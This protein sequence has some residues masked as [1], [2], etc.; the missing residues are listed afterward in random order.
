MCH[1]VVPVIES[2]QV[3]EARRV[4][5][6]VAAETLLT[7]ADRGKV[8]IVATEMANN[9]HRHARDGQILIRVV[10][11]ADRIG[12]EL[13]SIDRGP[14]MPNIARCMEDGF[15]SGGTAG[16][17]LGAI[18][19]L[20]AEFDIYSAQPSG[21]VILCRGFSPSRCCETAEL[22]ILQCGVVIARRGAGRDGLRR[23]LGRCAARRRRHGHDRRRSGPRRFGGPGVGRG[24]SSISTQS[25]FRDSPAIFLERAH[26]PLRSTRGAAVAAAYID[27]AGR[28]LCYAG[29]GNIC[30]CILD[31][32]DSRGLVSHNGTLG[33][34]YRRIKDIEY[35]WP[36]RGLLVMH[37]DGVNT[38]WDL[39]AYAGLAQ[40]HPAVVASVLYRDFTRGRDDVTVA[41]VR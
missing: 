14:G 15:S 16:N 19:R 12:I 31:G 26:N 27:L 6:R 5:S 8:A 13:L 33:L 28:R 2:S 21:T 3:G 1:T 23:Q 25:H 4:A 9:L 32:A 40:R 22:K 7:D 36:E 39:A 35:A 17:G 24:G 30:G 41:V 10:R 29:V 34:Q 18:R 38:R 20:S 11:D 37:S